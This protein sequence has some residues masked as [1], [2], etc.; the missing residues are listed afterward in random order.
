[1]V[2]RCRLLAIALAC[3]VG[4][5]NLCGQQPELS[6]KLSDPAFIEAAGVLE[7]I[8]RSPREREQYESRLKMERDEQ[9]RLQAARDQGEAK[10][11]EEG[12]AEGELVGQI[13]ILERLLAGEPNDDATLAKMDMEA[14]KKHLSDLQRRFTERG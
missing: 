14:L 2:N 7:M 3:F 5:T 12:R 9:A 11:R 4:A 8:A 6:T 10:G 1:M 13:R